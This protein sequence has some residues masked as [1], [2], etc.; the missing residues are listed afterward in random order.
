MSEAP[1]STPPC[2]FRVGD[3]FTLERTCDPHRPLYYAAAS[4]DFNE[5]HIDPKVGEKAGLGGVIL[6]GMCTMAWMVEA[7]VAYVGD[8]ARIVRSRTRFARPVLIG[9][10]LSYRGKVTQIV[11]GRLTAEISATNQRGEDVLKGGVVEALV[12]GAR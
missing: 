12:G 2:E 5:I 10:T 4:G 6:H 11:D 7:A 9:D 8:P 1:G 3:T